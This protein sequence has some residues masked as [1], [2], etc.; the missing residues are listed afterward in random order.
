MAITTAICNSYKQEVLD[1][2]H[3]T[4][5]VYKIALYTSAATL[6]AETKEFTTAGEVKGSGYSS[7]GLAMVGYR[8]VSDNGAAVLYWTSNPTW[9]RS[10]FTARGALIYNATRSSRALAVYDFGAD[11]TSTEGPFVVH[12]QA[13]TAETG[14]IVLR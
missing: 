10:T 9:A 11:I 7:G 3:Q 13:P 14:L 8:V 4:G 12:I 6:G 1:G 5:D 2:V